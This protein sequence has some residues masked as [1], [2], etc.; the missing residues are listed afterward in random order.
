MFEVLDNMDNLVE[1]PLKMHIVRNLQA[2]KKSNLSAPQ[3]DEGETLEKK[4]R[5]LVRACRE[6]LIE[7][8]S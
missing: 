4:K 7:W 2:P 5:E 8:L 3:E 1:D 6:I